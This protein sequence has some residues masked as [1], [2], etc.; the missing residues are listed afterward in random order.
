ML[1]R[2]EEWARIEA[3]LDRADEDDGGLLLLTGEPGIGKTCLLDEARVRTEASGGTVLF[4][5]GFEAAPGQ[6]VRRLGRR[7]AGRRR[8]PNSTTRRRLS[9]PA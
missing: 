6:N 8:S 2:A 4:G 5:R 9:S 3:F 7:V 1:G